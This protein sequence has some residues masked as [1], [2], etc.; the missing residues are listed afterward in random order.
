MAGLRF[1]DL[2]ARPTEL[3]DL[4][5]VAVEECH[6][7][8]PAFETAF[9]TRTATWRL[10]GKP[11]PAR[12]FPVY[13][14]CPLP[15]PEDRLLFRRVYLKTSARQ[16]VQWRLFGHGPSQHTPRIH[17]LLPLPPAAPEGP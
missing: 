16:V 14:P 11:R 13:T 1:S 7:L 17:N 5:S 3:L 15:T 8:V 4:S 10:D 2:Q 6:C 9:H 12:R